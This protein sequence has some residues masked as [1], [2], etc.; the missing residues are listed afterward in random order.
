MGNAETYKDTTNRL[1]I[2][3]KEYADIFRLKKILNDITFNLHRRN[4]EVEGAV[5]K[6][7]GLDYAKDYAISVEKEMPMLLS[8]CRIILGSIPSALTYDKPFLVEV[9]STCCGASPVSNIDGIDSELIG[10]CPACK[11]HTDFN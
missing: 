3:M 7:I 10:I 2:S 4:E 8:Q 5:S 9:F 6:G 11:E 1:G